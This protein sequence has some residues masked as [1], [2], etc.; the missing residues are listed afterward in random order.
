MKDVLIMIQVRGMRPEEVFRIRIENINWSQRLIFNPNG[1]TKAA[2]ARTD[3][4]TNGRPVDVSLCA[5]DR[6]LAI[7]SRGRRASHDC[8][9]AVPTGSQN[10]WSTGVVGFILRASY[11]WHDGVYR[12][13]KSRDGDERHG[14][15]DVRT[16]MRYQHPVL[17]SVREAI[18]QRNLRHKPRHNDLRVQ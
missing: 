7:T 11:L 4:R 9:K 17:D 15:T 3:Q 16:A 6:G 8:C 10:C 18:D 1:K 14:H 5:K 12:N 2:R 13:R